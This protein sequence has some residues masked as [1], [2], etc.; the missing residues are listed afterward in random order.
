M[1]IADNIKIAALCLT[2]IFILTSCG[3]AKVSETAAGS[4]AFVHDRD[5]ASSMNYEK[6]MEL[7]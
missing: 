5:V 7:D 3:S 6:S 2:V 4:E 1:K